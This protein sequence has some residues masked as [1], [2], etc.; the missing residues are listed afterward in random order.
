V[1]IF[2]YRC[3]KCD[4]TLEAIVLPGEEAPVACAACGGVLRRRWSRVGVQLIGWGFS[5]ND[6][7]LPDGRRRN[8]FRKVRDKAAE[9]FD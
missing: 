9:L 6:A 7:L 2:E 3:T 5:K 4:E 8:D 1:P